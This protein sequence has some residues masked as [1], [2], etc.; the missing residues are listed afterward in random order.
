MRVIVLLAIVV[1]TVLGNFA[2]WSLPNRPQPLEPPPGGK[3][4]SVSFAPFRDGQ[5]PLTRVYPTPEQVEED[6][7]LLKDEVMAVR[8]YTS[9]E[10]LENVPPLARKYGLKVMQGSWIGPKT[11]LNEEEVSE[12]IRLANTYPDVIDKV[13]VGNEVLLRNDR[14][15]DQLIEYIRRVKSQVKQPVTYADVW[16]WWLKYPQVADEVD[17][18]TIHLLPYWEDVPTSVED[19]EQ[20]ILDAYREIH[21][22]FPGKP[23]LVGEVGWPTAGRSRG[24]AKT[25]LVDK[26][27]FIN[28]FV[29]MAEREGFQY[30]I[31]EAFDQ[32]WK[33]ANEGTVGANWGL[34]STERER[35]FALAGPVVENP[36]WPRHF[37]L[38]SGLAILAL[39]AVAV[40]TPGLLGTLRPGRALVLAVLTQGMASA[41]VLA[42]HVWWTQT[43]YPFETV[44]AAALFA[45]D[46]VLAAAITVSAARL[47][48][49]PG[50]TK[51]GVMADVGAAAAW[52]MAAV[53]I[54]ATALLVF[55]GRYRD[56][57]VPDYLVP[58]VAL[59][60]LGVIRLLLQ[61]GGLSALTVRGALS[62][63]AGS[64][65]MR[66]A[67]AS[68]GATAFAILLP[69][70]AV[71]LVIT[72]GVINTE[73][74]TWA[75]LLV[76][77]SIP[78]VAAAL[79]RRN[80]KSLTKGIL[81]ASR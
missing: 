26:A 54:A 21:E 12:Q 33:S 52:I 1:I 53:A 27:K 29:R 74:M 10:G 30:N 32:G 5:S 28:Q 70:G 66:R 15:V 7:A 31:V 69:L 60:V 22:R 65:G 45:L 78:F 24:P 77:T 3:L 37:V 76:L 55:D 80:E 81:S 62:G 2:L 13:I 16:E 72:E 79:L 75:G 71:G 6:L 59:P 17:F 67:G 23:I 61:G 9:R 57:P 40:R 25:G 38:S 8:T 50:R 36:D 34:F 35:K 56:F 19:A 44:R 58:G 42:A 68:R 47:L 46:A 4:Q 14:T 11:D 73:A 48:T 49:D 63:K 39:L 43:Y 64:S 41:L 20:R 18:I 51:T